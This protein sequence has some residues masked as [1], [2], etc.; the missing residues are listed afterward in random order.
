MAENPRRKRQEMEF[1]AE[2]GRSIDYSTAIQA[3]GYGGYQTTEIFYCIIYRQGGITYMCI[4]NHY[5]K[6]DT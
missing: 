1:V 3:E 2:P 5:V 6:L 4:L